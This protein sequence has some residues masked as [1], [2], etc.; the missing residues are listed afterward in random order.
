MG[1]GMIRKIKEA[2]DAF[3]QAAKPIHDLMDEVL[4]RLGPEAAEVVYDRVGLYTG[5]L[6]FPEPRAGWQVLVDLEGNPVRKL[7]S[8]Y[9]EQVEVQ[10]DYAVDE[11]R[12]LAARFFL[13]YGDWD[14]LGSKAEAILLWEPEERRWGLLEARALFRGLEVKGE[15]LPKRFHEL[16]LR[17]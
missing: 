16:F 11:D 5:F 17:R 1:G 8:P 9:W 14:P 3:L 2:R 12:P 6:I 10:V 4:K 13:K 15:Y 7:P